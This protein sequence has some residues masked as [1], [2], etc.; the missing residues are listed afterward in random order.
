MLTQSVK[1]H[2]FNTA[3][4]AVA[5]ANDSAGVYTP[6]QVSVSCCSAAQVYALQLLDLQ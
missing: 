1:C 2:S 5:K 4:P 3:K 6:I